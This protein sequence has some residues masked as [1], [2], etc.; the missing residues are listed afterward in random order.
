MLIPVVCRNE[1]S[2]PQCNVSIVQAQQLGPHLAVHRPSGLLVAVLEA[3]AA[4]PPSFADLSDTAT[5][6]PPGGRYDAT[7]AEVQRGNDVGL[8]SG[9]V[10]RGLLQGLLED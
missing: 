5:S 6:P 8:A 4:P 2:M 7:L 9:G 3:P 10:L 1:Y